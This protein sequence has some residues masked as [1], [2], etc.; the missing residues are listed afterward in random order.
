MNAPEIGII[1]C[2][3]V[4]LG[5]LIS[6]LCTIA[7]PLLF[8]RRS[9]WTTYSPLPQSERPSP[10]TR[11]RMFLRD[12]LPCLLEILTGALLLLFSRSLGIVL[13]QGLLDHV[14]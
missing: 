10:A 12:Y 9:G 1:A 13:A 3:A 11:M 5:L 4:G 8:G 6:G 2:R 14:P 7:S